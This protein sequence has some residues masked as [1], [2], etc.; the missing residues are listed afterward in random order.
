QAFWQAQ[1]LP[2][3]ARAFEDVC[4][5]FPAAPEAA[6]AGAALKRL[7]AQ[8]GAAF[9]AVTEEVQAHRAARL[10][11][12]LRYHDALEEYGALPDSY[13]SSAS[14]PVWRLARARCLIRLKRVQDAVDA[15]SG[16][17]AGNPEPES[18]RLAA[19]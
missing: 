15:L 10:S 17:F 12:A 3:A 2:E 13:P 11:S 18:E 19:V 5:A 4:Y 8:L 1:Q 9:P 14:G 6:V 7:K 16:R